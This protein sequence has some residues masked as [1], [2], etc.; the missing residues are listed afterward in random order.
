LSP[1]VVDTEIAIAGGYED[2]NSDP[3]KPKENPFLKPEDVS[4]CV[5]FLLST[6][7]NVDVTEI[8]VKPV[9]EKM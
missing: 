1:G 9:G 7:Y 2:P 3:N 5:M 8:I 4:Q 6:P